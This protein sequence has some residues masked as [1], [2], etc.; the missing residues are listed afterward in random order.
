MEFYLAPHGNDRWSGTRPRRSAAHPGDGPWATPDGALNR[1]AALKRQGRLTG[2]VTVWCA[3]GRTELAA[4][5]IIRPDRAWPITFKA[6]PGASPL[7]SGGTRIMG[8]KCRSLRGRPVWTVDLPD[9]RAGR[10]AFRSLFVNGRRAPRP[11]WPRAGLSRIAAVPGLTLPTSWGN[12]GQTLFECAPGDVRPFHNLTD[13]ELVLLHFWIEERSPI[14]AF[15]PDTRR[16]TMARPSRAPLVGKSGSQLADYYLDNV[17]EAL[18]EPGEWYLDRPRGRL[19]YRPR[20]GDTP[21]TTEI[22]APRLLQLVVCEGHV[23]TDQA[24]EQIRFE[25]LHFAHT[26]W[27]H[28]SH[29]GAV[30]RGRSRPDRHSRG[31]DAAASQAACDVPGV[32]AFEAARHCA[33]ED[34]RLDNLGWYGVSIGDACTDIR[35][36]GCRIRDT[37]AGGVLINGA[38]ASHP[39]AARRRTG[40]VTITD[41]TLQEGG[42]IFH[43]AVGILA[44]NAYRVT[45]AHNLIFDYFYTAISCGWEW[46]YQQSASHSNTIAYNHIHTIGQGLLSDMGG[47]YTLGVQPGTVIRNNLVHGVRS[48]HY[49][50]WCLYPDEGSS[51]LLIENNVCFDADREVFHQHYGRENL[52]V[53]NIL[54]FGREAALRV[55]RAEPHISL[56]LLRNIVV[57]DGAPMVAL[58]GRAPEADA[59]IRSDANL[60]FDVAGKPPRFRLAGGSLAGLAAWKAL[61]YDR[62]SRSADPGFTGL[63]KRHFTLPSDSPAFALG[64]RPIDLSRVGPRPK[65]KRGPVCGREPERQGLL[66]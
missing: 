64:F 11:R 61:G 6:M 44:M 39:D 8:W 17:F 54:A 27:R 22:I 12:G 43:S 45:L 30:V 58:G 56:T 20:P 52:V 21:A 63:K 47:I 4:P 5:L 65:G 29:D 26:D 3:A 9:V 10:W 1:I 2:P 50:G 41:N 31:R 62:H 15:D 48:A 19:Y 24:V 60:F 25:G 33:L 18:E 7:W 55:S 34:C 36:V 53:N 46:G 28:P 49:G 51:H 42:R 59:T 14:A 23:D 35:L 37:G 16:V 32:I 13:V 38:E 57:S 66:A 40:V